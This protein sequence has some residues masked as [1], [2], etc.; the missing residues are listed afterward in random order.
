MD[1]PILV[2]CWLP[3]WAV[4]VCGC[5]GSFQIE[6]AKMLHAMEPRRE[7]IIVAPV[8]LTARCIVLCDASALGACVC[9]KVCV[10]TSFAK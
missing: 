7:L 6:I 9:L 5:G 4:L 3:D 1:E 2:Y 10:C 8:C